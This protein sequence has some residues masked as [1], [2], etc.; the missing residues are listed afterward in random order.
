MMLREKLSGVKTYKE[1]VYTEE[2]LKWSNQGNN[3]V[4]LFPG[5]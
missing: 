3:T 1:A 4:V 5:W 2:V